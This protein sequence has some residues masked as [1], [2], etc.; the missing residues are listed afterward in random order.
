MMDEIPFAFYGN[1]N[2]EYSQEEF[3]L[4][5]SHLQPY[6]KNFNAF[7]ERFLFQ[8]FACLIRSIKYVKNYYENNW[9]DSSFQDKGTSWNQYHKMI[10][11]L[12]RVV[13]SFTY[14]YDG[15][16]GSWGE[17]FP[18]KK[19]IF[20][21][22]KKGQEISLEGNVLNILSGI[23][24]SFNSVHGKTNEQAMKSFS[25]D[26]YEAYQEFMKEWL[27]INAEEGTIAKGIIKAREESSKKIAFN[28][29][30]Y[31]LAYNI[32]FFLSKHSPKEK[33]KYPSWHCRFIGQFFELLGFF[34]Y[35]GYTDNKK[36]QNWIERGNPLG[37]TTKAKK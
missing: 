8:G 27:T 18:I 2:N 19:V 21:G 9:T 32:H 26:F 31:H 25:F 20:K 10:L 35:L 3:Q 37:Q 34:T 13:Q 1:A 24:K 6:L 5:Q 36:V 12:N 15:K 11:N 30:K 7:D 23:F 29:Y 33:A 4:A 16:L 17:T 22:A 14:N 28:K